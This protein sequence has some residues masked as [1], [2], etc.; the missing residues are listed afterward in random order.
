MA[1]RHDVAAGVGE[2]DV[3]MAQRRAQANHVHWNQSTM[4]NQDRQQMQGRRVD[5]ERNIAAERGQPKWP[6]L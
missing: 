6:F 3:G 5:Q 2:M 4:R 1:G